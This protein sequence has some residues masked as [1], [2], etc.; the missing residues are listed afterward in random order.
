MLVWRTASSRQIGISV[1]PL[2]K[3]L[4]D[5]FGV[6]E[7]TLL[8]NNV[9]ENSPASRAGLKAGD[10]IVEVEG[11]AVHGDGELI[12]AI[13]AKTEGD[14]HITIVRDRARQT[15]RVTPET[16]KSDL[17]RSPE[18][19]QGSPGGFRLFRH[20]PGRGSLPVEML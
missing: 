5:H 7:G 17:P 10:I 4:G 16:V 20:A 15:I 11:K 14:V 13:G 1:S 19:F 9:R 6:A 12:R 3:Q 8:I 18:H 2:T